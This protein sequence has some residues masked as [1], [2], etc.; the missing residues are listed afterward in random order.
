MCAGAGGGAQCLFAEDILG[1]NEG[2]VPRYAKT[3]RDLEA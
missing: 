3:Y 1:A 2:K